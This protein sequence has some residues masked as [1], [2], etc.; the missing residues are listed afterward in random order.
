D[1]VVQNKRLAPVAGQAPT[2]S[3]NRDGIGTGFSGPQG[4]FSVRYAP[5]DNNG[6]VGTTQFVETV[7]VALAVFDK[8]TGAVLYGP[9]N[10]HTLWG[11]FAGTGCS[12]NNDGDPTVVFDHI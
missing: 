11:G 10:I 4:S 12:T 3:L 6:A 9:G 5:P 2:A 7:N 8:G 1:A